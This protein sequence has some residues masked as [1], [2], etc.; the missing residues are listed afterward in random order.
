[1]NESKADKA[2]TELK[3]L[4]I[5]Q[6]NELKREMNERFDNVENRL[7][8]IEND[9]ETIAENTEHERDTKGELRKAS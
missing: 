5:N 1:M 7:E 9:V 4:I 8:N 2:F 3:R 6:H